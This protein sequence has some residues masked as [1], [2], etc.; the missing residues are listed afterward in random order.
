MNRCEVREDSRDPIG[1]KE[2]AEVEGRLFA[3]AMDNPAGLYPG[4]APQTW[5]VLDF[6]RT[7]L[8]TLRLAIAAWEKGASRINDCKQ[9]VGGRVKR[10]AQGWAGEIGDRRDEGPASVA[11]RIRRPVHLLKEKTSELGRSIIILQSA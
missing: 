10:R 9:S 11:T 8:R 4:L 6:V 1:S 2:L 5:S 3:Q 7:D